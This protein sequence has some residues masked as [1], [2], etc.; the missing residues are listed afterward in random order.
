MRKYSKKVIIVF[1][2]MFVISCEKE[3][4]PYQINDTI[5]ID[6]E[7]IHR[8]AL[9]IGIDGFRSDVMNLTY[10]PF[11]NEL[12]QKKNTFSSLNHICEGIT[13][14][15]PNWSSIL[16]GVHMNKHQVFNNSFDDDKFDQ[17]P[18]FFYFVSESYSGK[19]TASIVNWL[20]I[21]NKLMNYFSDY[22]TSSY[23][24]DFLVFETTKNLIND[25][26]P[27][28]ADII[29]IQFDELDGTGHSFGF[30]SEVEEYVNKANEIDSY[31]NQLYNLIEDKRSAGED[32]IFII[33]SDH[34]GEGT[35]HGDADNPNVN[36][37]LISV[38]H[39]I[40]K[41]KN[42]NFYSNQAD[43]GKTDQFTLL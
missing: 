10:T 14:S 23:M 39:P 37:T 6:Q 4:S 34:G 7:K 35:S 27:V 17:Y 28:N 15:G 33:V 43:I 8:K 36:R 16:T 41:F 38:E 29:F 42:S 9:I 3:N 2:I 19:K 32:W 21:N 24:N 25:N 13:Y 31:C 20:P 40:L 12:I 11:I 30:S 26:N 22:S 18:S 5:T 1:V